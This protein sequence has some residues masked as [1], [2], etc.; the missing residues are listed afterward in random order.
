MNAEWRFIHME[1][2]G[3]AAI[4][5]NF[6]VVETPTAPSWGRA[7]LGGKALWVSP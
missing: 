2:V 5:H 6:A 1:K 4:L 7:L 3:F